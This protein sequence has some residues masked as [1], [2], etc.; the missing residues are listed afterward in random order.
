MDETTKRI[1]CIAYIVK[2]HISTIERDLKHFKH[3]DVKASVPTVKILKKQF[4]NE[5]HFE[6]VPLLF[7]YG[8]FELPFDKACNESYLGQLRQDVAA[9]FAWVKDP[10]VVLSKKPELNKDNKLISY[11]RAAIAT[12]SEMAELIKQSQNSSVYLD[13]DISKVFPGK[14]VVLKGY[15]FDDLPAEVISINRRKKEVKVKLNPE[16]I[17]KEVTVSFDNIFY[18]IYECY[19]DDSFPHESLDEMV[20]K[21]RYMVDKLY[22]HLQ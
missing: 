22:V 2:D 7:N 13:S 17:M 8:F 20:E 3:F 5:K 19:D 9:I 1:W 16:S 4:K 15:P 10:S 6:E 11:P 14:H 12:E 18:T 21:N